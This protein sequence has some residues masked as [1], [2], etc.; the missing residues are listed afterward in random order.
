MC[1]KVEQKTSDTRKSHKI[2]VDLWESEQKG[3][4]W[5]NVAQ[6]RN[7]WRILVNMVWNLGLHTT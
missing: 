5:V 2:I 1:R 4:N 6:D 7:K 3:M